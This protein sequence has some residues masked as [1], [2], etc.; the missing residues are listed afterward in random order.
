MNLGLLSLLVLVVAIVI[1]FIKK[2]NVGILAI[3]L[4]LVVGRIAGIADKDVIKG[5]DASLFVTLLGVTFLFSIINENKA[6]LVGAKKV[7]LLIGKRTWLLPIMM[8]AIGYAI[9]AAGPGAIP[10]LALMPA[11][12]IPL[13][14]EMGY[15]PLML[16]IIA[17]L[18]VMSG[19]MNTITPEGVVITGI[20]QKQKISGFMLH[21]NLAMT[22]TCII[23]AIIVYIYY[24]GYK[25]KAVEGNVQSEIPKFNNKQIIS[26]LGLL[27]MIVMVIFLKFNPGLTAFLIGAVLLMLGVADEGK[28]IKGIPW[29]VLLLVS[30]VGVLMQL[31]ISLGGIKMLSSALAS[32]MN[33]Y[34]AG[35]IMGITSG[36]MSWFSSGLGVVFPTLMPTVGGIAQSVGHG[37]S[38]PELIAAIGIGGTITGLSPASTTGGLILATIMADEG[39]SKEKENQIF[40]HLWVWSVVALVLVALLAILGVY[41]IL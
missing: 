18:G 3:G 33:Q 37:V 19:R 32:L 28:S 20:L 23:L 2:M 10:S 41:R 16:A 29:S 25:V 24:K 26:L 22:V 17:D 38:V 14:I 30:G 21:M 13:A 35:S 8:Y 27:V 9:C 11:F 6:L 4:A 36:I 5:F 7:V 34:T 40:I 31:S 39:G 15:N 1:G 12:A